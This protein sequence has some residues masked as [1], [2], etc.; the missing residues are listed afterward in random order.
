M[1][2]QHPIVFLI[3]VGNTLLDSDAIEQDSRARL[4]S[5]RRERN[6]RILEDLF[7]ELGFCDYIGCPRFSWIVH[8]QSDCFP[9]PLTC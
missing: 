1:T 4:R 7:A 8:S 6:C 5:S 2:P 3:G 9:S